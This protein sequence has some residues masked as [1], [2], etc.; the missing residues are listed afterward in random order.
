M[1]GIGLFLLATLGRNM[2]IVLQ[3]FIPICPVNLIALLVT[4]QKNFQVVTRHGNTYIFGAG[5]A[6]FHG[7]LPDNYWW[8]YCKLVHGI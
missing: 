3:S 8:N 4:L 5:P 1:C 6:L 7:I 2:A